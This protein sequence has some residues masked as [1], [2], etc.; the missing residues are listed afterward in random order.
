MKYRGLVEVY[1]YI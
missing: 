1:W